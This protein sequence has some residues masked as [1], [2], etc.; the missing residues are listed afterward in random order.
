MA[1]DLQTI[2]ANINK[3]TRI[4]SSNTTLTMGTND[5]PVAIL[6]IL[7]PIA[8]VID[9]KMWGPTWEKNGVEVKQKH[10]QVAME[11]YPQ[12]TNAH[13]EKGIIILIYCFESEQYLNCFI[14]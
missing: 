9:R 2:N 1:I 10:L 13:I 5:S 4:G 6:L 11:K 3:Q 8:K 7:L 12:H 14:G